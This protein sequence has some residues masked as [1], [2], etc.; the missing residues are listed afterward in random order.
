[1]DREL[2]GSNVLFVIALAEHL[3][4]KGTGLGVSDEPADHIA[5]KNPR[6]PRTRWPREVTLPG[7]PQI[8]TCRT[9]ASGSSGH[10][11]AP[12]RQMEWMATG[13][14]S[15]YRWRSRLKRSHFIHALEERRSSHFLQTRT[16]S[17]R[18]R[19]SADA[20]PVIP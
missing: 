8:R 18:K 7:L 6:N 3:L 17:Y 5:T 4:G 14:G 19:A 9:T 10:G 15:G 13:T 12:R 1:M 16:T 20:F 2:S 11:L